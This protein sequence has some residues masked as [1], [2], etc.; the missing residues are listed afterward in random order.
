MNNPTPTAIN[1]NLST[2]GSRLGGAAIAAEFH[3]RQMAESFP[4]ELWRMWDCDEESYLDK[5][6]IVNFKSKTKF[7]LLDNYLPRKL[8][9]FFL[10]SDILE[11]VATS[12]PKIIHLHNPIPSI[13]FE[14][15]AKRSSQSGIKVAASTHGFYEVMNPNFNFK[16]YE[17]WVWKKGITAPVV[18]SLEYIDAFFSGYPSEKEML[19]NLGVPEDKIYL[20]PNGVNPF[21][22]ITPTQAELDATTNKFSLCLDRPII[23]FIGNHNANKGLDTVMKISSQLSEP[24]TMVVGGKLTTPDEPQN[25]QDKFPKSKSVDIVFTDYLTTV[26]QRALYRLSDMLLFPSL[27]DTLPLTIIEAMATELPVIAYDVG[28]IS[29]Q[30]QDGCGIIVKSGDFTGF[31]SAVEKLISDSQMRTEIAKKAKLRQEEIFSWE[32]TARTTIDVY[33]QLLNPLHE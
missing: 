17:K 24:C 10:D 2:S 25:W 20:A 21:F 14:K 11:Q 4:V 26:E 22:L 9:P 23:L 5:L 8:K 33:K 28:G 19:V 6:K 27:A 7:Y 3:S 18:R 32:K 15:I 31:L 16:S 12:A 30:L 29:Y 13:A 1:I